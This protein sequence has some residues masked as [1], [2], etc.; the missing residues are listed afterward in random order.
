MSQKRNVDEERKEG[1]VQGN[2]NEDRCVK[3]HKTLP[4]FNTLIDTN[5][6]GNHNSEDKP[7]Q[8]Q[9]NTTITANNTNYMT[10]QN[11][12]T[13][14][15]A[16]INTINTTNTDNIL[17]PII[18]TNTVTPKKIQKIPTK[19]LSLVDKYANQISNK[20]VKLNFMNLAHSILNV[21]TQT[22]DNSVIYLIKGFIYNICYGSNYRNIKSK[23]RYLR[24]K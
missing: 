16:P 4:T 1:E 22:D 24:K 12:T 8:F 11:N 10:N 3:K 17:P 9:F 21:T 13:N 14:S 18:T 6:T 19:F 2:F 23:Y 7:N 5:F 20:D 15:F